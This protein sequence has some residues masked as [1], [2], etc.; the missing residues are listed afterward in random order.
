MDGGRKI[1]ALTHVLEND[2][3]RVEVSDEG[4]EL[5]RVYDKKREKEA[6]WTADPK[7]W[8]RHAPVL[9][10]FVGKVNGGFY[11]FEGQKYPMG[12]HGFA[13]DRVFTCTAESESFV[14]HRL[15]ADEEG[16][17]VYPFE[18]V[19]EITHKLEGNCVT[20]EWKVENPG[21]KT[22][23][24]SIGG[25]PG[26]CVTK[27]EGS[28]LVFDGQESLERMA[29]DLEASAV[30]T[31]HPET[32]R[33][34]DGTY[35]VDAHTFDKDALI[36][37]NSQVKKVSLVDA[38]GDCIVTMR[39]PDALSVGIWAPEGG[40]APFICL[41]PWIGRCDNKGFAGELKDKFDEQSLEAGQSF[42]SAYEMVFG[43]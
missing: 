9:F 15:E 21:E 42:L 22:M 2:L 37:D 33:L 23:Y 7:F 20:V 5:V 41:E 32:I 29:I 26:F 4:A 1:M 34:Q 19:L 36:F 40:E 25:H 11:T 14:T 24:F 35:T 30:D 43:E 10:P 16:R 6:L 27:Q 18:F 38:D 8:G 31:D 3:L 13:R 17:K 12:Q 28:R 39:C